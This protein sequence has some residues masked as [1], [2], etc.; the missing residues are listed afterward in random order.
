MRRVLICDRVEDWLRAWPLSFGYWGIFR[1]AIVNCSFWLHISWT[2]ENVLTH[3]SDFLSDDNPILTNSMNSVMSHLLG[4]EFSLD[5]NHS[6][7]VVGS[8]QTSNCYV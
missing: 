4:G 6:A 3:D 1:P 7:G 2:G 5:C 8:F